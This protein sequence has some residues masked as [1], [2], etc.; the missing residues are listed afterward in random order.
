M[1]RGSHKYESRAM[2]RLFALRYARFT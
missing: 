2:T 1:E